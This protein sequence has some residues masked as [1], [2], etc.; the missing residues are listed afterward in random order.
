MSRFY[1]RFVQASA[2]GWFGGSYE[3]PVTPSG[4]GGTRGLVGGTVRSTG[5]VH[6]HDLG[7]GAVPRSSS[8]GVGERP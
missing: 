3:T 7:P 5:P 8:G 2:T 4:P 6:G 1:W